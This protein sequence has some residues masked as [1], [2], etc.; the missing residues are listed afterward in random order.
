MR[1]RHRQIGNWPN[2]ESAPASCVNHICGA[3]DTYN[4]C[5]TRNQ[6]LRQDAIATTE[7]QNALTWPRRK[8]VKHR[9]TEGRDECG[10][11]GVSGSVPGLCGHSH[12]VV[13]AKSIR[14]Y[15]T[16]EEW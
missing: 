15:S 2:I 16:M 11:G 6:F 5:S 13:V 12:I 10:I 1:S 9:L 8:Q 3:I 14:E 4:F 7:V